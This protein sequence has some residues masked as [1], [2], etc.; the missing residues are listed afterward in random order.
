VD[1]VCSIP[2]FKDFLQPKTYDALMKVSSE[3]PVVVLVG[4]SSTYAALLLHP[5]GVDAI[6]CKGAH[7]H[8]NGTVPKCV[9]KE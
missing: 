4:Y 8:N 3:R 7:S 9:I 5:S 2:G 6:Y 1:E